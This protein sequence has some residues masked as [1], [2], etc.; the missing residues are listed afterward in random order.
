MA[1]ITASVYVACAVLMPVHAAYFMPMASMHVTPQD[2]PMAEVQVT[3]EECQALLPPDTA[4][5]LTAISSSPV[6]PPSS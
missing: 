5:G 4:L 2:P 3:R 6:A 1:T